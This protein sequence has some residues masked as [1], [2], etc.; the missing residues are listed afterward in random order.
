MTIVLMMKL[1]IRPVRGQIRGQI[2][3]VKNLLN[4]LEARNPLYARN[5]LE[6]RNPNPVGKVWP[7]LLYP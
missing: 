2:V 1:I 3:P 5:P 7:Q 4:P 6:A